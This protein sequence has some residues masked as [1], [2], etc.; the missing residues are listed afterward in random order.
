VRKVLLLFFVLAVVGSA[1]SSGSKTVATVNGYEIS[2]SDVQALAPSDGTV[3]TATFDGNLRNLVIE[4]AVEQA[5]EQEWG[6]SID[7]GAIDDK[8][9]EIL[10]SI[11]SDDATIDDY[12][13]SNSITRD[14]IRH[15]AIQ[16]LLGSAIDDQLASQVA[17][18]TD[19][20]LQAA[21]D[22]NKDAQTTVCVHHILVDTEDEAN[23]VIDRLNNGESFADVAA[24]VSTD[25]NSG[26][27]G[28]DLG[29][30]APSSYVSEFAA[31][32]LAAPIGEVYGP[33]QT[34]YGFHV[35]IV[36]SREVPTFDDMKADLI[37]QLKN[38]QASQLF[39]DWIMAKLDAAAIDVDPKYGTWA[40]SPDYAINPPA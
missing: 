20:E 30:A 1:C 40:G 34:D 12:L 10:A 28:G 19:E 17:E 3:D 24:E 2:L 22:A 6:V 13:S 38:Q 18:P 11:G 4:K 16:Q 31:A 14:T 32:T 5:A 37:T 35:L 27:N 36:D 9:N 7:Q 15:V 29:C 21:Y 8:Y 39:S 33:V 23:Q 26:Q 25:T